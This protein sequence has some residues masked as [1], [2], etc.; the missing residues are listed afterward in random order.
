MQSRRFFAIA[1]FSST[2]AFSSG[3]KIESMTEYYFSRGGF[4]H[5]TCYGLFRVTTIFCVNTY[6]RVFALLSHLHRRH[7]RQRKRYTHLHR[8]RAIR[9]CANSSYISI[10][11]SNLWFE[12]NVT[13]FKS[14]RRVLYRDKNRYLPETSGNCRRNNCESYTDLLDRPRFTPVVKRNP[15]NRATNWTEEKK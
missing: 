10:F 12:T 8:A 3:R 2:H 14:Q 4:S 15:L 5:A 7:L 6:V 1:R 9:S 11:C 13:R